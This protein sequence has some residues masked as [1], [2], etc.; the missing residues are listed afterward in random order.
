MKKFF[1]WAGFIT[2]GIIIGYSISDAYKGNYLSA[3]Y[4]VLL[5]I[6]LAQFNQRYK[7]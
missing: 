6:A 4:M 5:V 2:D 7:H 1:H 3:I